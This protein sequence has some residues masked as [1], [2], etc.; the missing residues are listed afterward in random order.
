MSLTENSFIRY[1]FASHPCSLELSLKLNPA[2]YSDD[3]APSSQST[4]HA[5]I[6][7]IFK[8]SSLFEGGELHIIN[9]GVRASMWED[10]KRDTQRIHSYVQY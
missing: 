2:P 6:I 9:A 8:V 7:C 4:S 1:L 5:N 10:K 3:K